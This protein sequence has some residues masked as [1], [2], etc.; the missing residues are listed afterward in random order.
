MW[1]LNAQFKKI[2][3]SDEVGGFFAYNLY[4]SCPV[5]ELEASK[6]GINSALER[7]RD[8]HQVCALC[9][10]SLAP[11]SPSTTKVIYF[12]YC[13]TTVGSCRRCWPLTLPWQF[14]HWLAW[15]S[16]CQS[17]PRHWSWCQFPQSRQWS[18]IQ[19]HFWLSSGWHALFVIS[20][21]RHDMWLIIC[22]VLQITP[23]YG[24]AI[25]AG[26]RVLVFVFR[27]RVTLFFFSTHHTIPYSLCQLR[28]QL[29]RMWF[30]NCSGWR[31]FRSILQVHWNE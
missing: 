23:V 13:A 29:W 31:Y 28:R 20:M 12:L 27:L 21:K 24:E 18:R 7:R 15:K 30:A 1:I 22:L 26:L 8:I 3:V 16:Y 11:P 6:Y 25:K 9:C 4:N 10:V 5:G 17:C 19:L 14:P 2:K